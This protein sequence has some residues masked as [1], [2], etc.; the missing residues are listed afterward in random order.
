[1][2][3]D[4]GDEEEPEGKKPLPQLE[5]G[6]TVKLEKLNREQQFTQPPARYTEATLI[7]AMEEKG[8]GRPS[9]YAPTISTI[10]GREY[11]AKEGKYL[12]PTSLGEVVTTL[13]MER[14]PDVVDM[15]FTANMEEKLDEIEEGKVPW[16]TVLEDFYGNFDR[17][18]NAAEEALAGTHIKVPDEVTQEICDKCGRNLV[19][20]SGRFGRFLPARGTRSATLPNRW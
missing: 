7:R 18:Y 4:H 9:T 14:F 10:T 2:Y 1:M 5:E 16:R 13:M 20:K 12:R 3:E 6:E 19:I 8:I 17:E 15:K 11:V